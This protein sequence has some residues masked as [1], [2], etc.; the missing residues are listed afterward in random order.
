MSYS[1]LFCFLCYR[2]Q[3]LTQKVHGCLLRRGNQGKS[4]AL[5][6]IS[7]PEIMCSHLD[8]CKTFVWHNL[9][10][11]E[12]ARS[13][14]YQGHPLTKTKTFK[15]EKGK[16]SMGMVRFALCKILL[17]VQGGALHW[18]GGAFNFFRSASSIWV[19]IICFQWIAGTG[20]GESAMETLTLTRIKLVG[21]MLVPRT[22][23]LIRLAML[24]MSPKKSTSFTEI[25]N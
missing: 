14:S 1:E 12:G 19:V 17:G 5:L 22:S 18:L 24:S 23:T 15:R 25:R 3:R 4:A 20:R 8:L 13:R 21:R 2:L 9:H 11:G 6:Q 10:Y 16:M 7:W